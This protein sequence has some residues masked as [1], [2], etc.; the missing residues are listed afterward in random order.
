[1]PEKTADR[2]IEYNQ[3]K[4]RGLRIE[5]GEDEGAL[6]KV[7][8][9][10]T[11]LVKIAKIKGIE[12][13]CAYFTA[14]RVIDAEA[15]KKRLGETLPGYMVPTAYLQLK[16][17]PMTLNGKIDAKSLPEA[18]IYRSGA[19][20]KVANKI[21]EDFG[22]I[23]GSI[24][25]LEDVGAAESFF[26]IGGTSLLV[27]R[28]VIMAQKLGYKIKFADVFLNRSPRSKRQRRL[29]LSIRKFPTT[30]TQS[31]RRFST[32]IRRT[33]SATANANC[34]AISSSRARRATWAFTSCMNSLRITRAKSTVSCAA[35]RICLPKLTSKLSCS[36]RGSW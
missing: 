25:Q 15:L 22:K 12:H 32:R 10:K 19:S 20:A 21:E 34:S 28:V 31:L 33:N 23:F 27:T 17:M 24:L 1:M 13:L 35:K 26:D 7:D 30:T 11:F 6:A 2:F 29:R 14:D 36:T 9:I 5:L 4:L 16:K 8:G 18:T 3:I